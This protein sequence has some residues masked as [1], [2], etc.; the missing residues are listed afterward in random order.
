VA[1]LG[2]RALFNAQCLSII[3]RFSSPVDLFQPFTIKRGRP[4]HAS[5][6]ASNSLPHGFEAPGQSGARRG[7]RRNDSGGRAISE[8]MVIWVG[9]CRSGPV[10]SALSDLEHEGCIHELATEGRSP[11][12][13][14]IGRCR[15]TRAGGGATGGEQ[16]RRN[17]G[18]PAQGAMPWASISGAGFSCTLRGRRCSLPSSTARQ[19]RRLDGCD[20]RLH[21]LIGV[22]G[23]LSIYAYYFTFL[24]GPRSFRHQSDLLDAIAL[25][26]SIKANHMLHSVLKMLADL[27]DVGRPGRNV[28]EER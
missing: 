3:W 12:R 9:V 26:S 20:H 16:G 21:R 24:L 27:A 4:R 25:A 11:G 2:L 14:V 19:R 18:S 15:Q 22:G 6:R 10:S 13:D 23:T 1:T 17:L 28:R 5:G 8:Q 7:C